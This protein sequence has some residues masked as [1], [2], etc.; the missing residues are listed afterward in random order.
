MSGPRSS[1]HVDT[2]TRVL[3]AIILPFLAAA[4]VLLY[5]LP[6]QTEVTFAWTITP[7]LTAMFLASAY[8][9]GIVFF[10]HV[11]RTPRWHRVKYGFPAVLVFATL[12]SIATFLHWD[13]FHFGH[14]SFFTWVT[15]YVTTPVLVLVAIFRNW[16][17]DS[18]VA[19]RTQNEQ[20]DYRIARGPRVVI[21]TVG[22]VAFACGIVLFINPAPFV[23]SWAWQLTPLT[24]RVVGAVLTLPGVVNVWLLVDP[25]WSS[26]RLIFQ[27]E[28]VSLAFIALAIVFARG[29]I[30]W[31][32]PA[33][34]AFVVGIGVSLVAFVAFYLFCERPT[35]AVRE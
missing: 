6:S 24:A 5:L 18:S 16:R 33:G 15:L 14:I 20:R 30:A 28:I 4:V 13:R 22:I 25:R 31:D 27:A 34:P 35:S 8:V 2:Y 3:A 7:T 32:R 10:V 1:D 11:L 17:A 9:G 26:F 12:L 29:D 19:G 21:A 23:D